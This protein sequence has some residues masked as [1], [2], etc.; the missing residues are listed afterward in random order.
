M[1][2]NMRTREGNHG[3]SVSKPISPP[4]LSSKERRLVRLYEDDFALRFSPGSAPSYFSGLRLFLS[5]LAERGL[6]VSEVRTEDLLAYQSDLLAVRQEDGTPYAISTHLHRL[7]AVKSFFSFLRRR[8]YLL[9]DPAAALELPKEERRL[10]IVLTPSEAKRILERVRGGS[11][12]ELR[13][14][15]I[16][17]LFYATGIR[18]GELT[19]LKPYDVDTEERRLHVVLGKGRRGRVVPLTGASARAIDAYLER[20]RA[21]L[22]KGNKAPWLFLSNGGGRMHC[23]RL[24]A[25]IQH[26]AGRAGVKKH[27]TCHTFRH[28]VATHLLKGRAD[29]RHIQALLGHRS[30][31]STE[32]YTR[33]EVSDLKEVLARA[34]PRGR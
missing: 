9:F 24:N 18:V 5:W 23:S 10:P 34:H 32:R 3:A 13:D 28:S 20:G 31:Q 12:Q 17:E 33:V 8:G 2:Q 11:P 6:A 25:M 30:L 21:G 19:A 4:T 16:L 14:R 15:A 27:V 1:T 26:Y 22:M 29:I 7:I